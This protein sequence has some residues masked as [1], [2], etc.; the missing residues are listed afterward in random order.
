MSF[1]YAYLLADMN[2][3]VSLGPCN[4]YIENVTATVAKSVYHD[5]VNVNYSGGGSH[6]HTQSQSCS[7][8]NSGSGSNRNSDGCRDNTVYNLPVGML[9]CQLL[10]VCLHNSNHTSRCVF[11]LTI[12]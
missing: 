6:D 9:L 2:M 12:L 10:S 11:C 5:S 7:G 8:S 3:L 1:W 4:A